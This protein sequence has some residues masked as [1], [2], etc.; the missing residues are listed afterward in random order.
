M[1]IIYS[2][3]EQTT[4]NDND[5][6]L[7]TS[8]ALVGGKKKNTT[9]NF[10]LSELS[11]YFGVGSI[12]NPIA[13]DFKLA[14]F[15]QGGTKI[16]DSIISQDALA[17][18]SV[19]IAGNLAA[20][21]TT[22]NGFLTVNGGASLGTGAAGELIAFGSTTRLNA[23]IQD[24]LGVVGTLDQ[25][26]ISDT[27]G[28]VS[29]QNYTSGLTY[30][31][32]WDATNNVTAP[33]GV[34]IVSSIG[35]NGE[36]YI[37][38]VAGNTQLNGQ[39]VTPTTPPYW[40]V[41]DWVVFVENGAAGVWQKIDNTSVLT[42]TG[43]DNKIAM[44]TGG[45]TPSV[46]LTDS[47]ISQDAGASTVTVAGAFTS[48]GNINGVN[49]TGT[50][51]LSGVNLLLT[52]TVSLNTQ[53]GNSGQVLTSQGTA[54]AIWANPTPVNNIT[55]SGTAN[56]LSMF[57][58]Q[59]TVGDSAVTQSADALTVDVL[60][61]TVSDANAYTINTNIG[62]LTRTGFFPGAGS[63]TSNVTIGAQNT[64]GFVDVYGS[65]M[66]LRTYNPPNTAS[67]PITLWSSSTSGIGISLRTE[68][69]S[70][71][72]LAGTYSI[73]AI[74]AGAGSNPEAIQIS[75]NTGIKFQ[76]QGNAANINFRSYN[77]N[78]N[79]SG[80]INF[81]SE[82]QEG[83]AG[84]VSFS[85][86]A[87]DANG[88]A[89]EIRLA[90]AGISTS[91]TDAVPLGLV[92]ASNGHVKTGSVGDTYTLGS[93]TDGSNVK[94]NLDAANG[95]DSAVT[96][97]G[98]GGLTIAQ[99]ND[100]VTLTAPASSDTTYTLAAG[101]KSATSVPLNLTPSTGS[102]T[103]VNLT[104][105]TGITLTQTSATEITIAGVAQ[106]VT[107]S[108]TVN[109]LPKF[110]TTT[111]LSDSIV[112]QGGGTTT[113]VP[114]NNGP[115]ISASI[116]FS[117]QASSFVMA[118]YATRNTVTGPAPQVGDV[119][120]FVLTSDLTWAIGGGVIPA[121]TYPFTITFVGSGSLT[122]NFNSYT[123]G[124]GASGTGYTNLVGNGSSTSVSSSSNLSIDGE[125]SMLT[126][127]I[128]NVVNPI[129]NQDAATKA[130]VDNVVSGQLIF[131]GSYDATTAPPFGPSILQGFTYVVNVAGDYGGLWPIPLAVG[132]LIISN[133]DNPVDVGDYT[134]VNKQVDIATDT[135]LGIANFP[136]GNNGL[137]V[138]SG[139][140]TAKL[141]SGTL[142]G[143]VPDATSAPAGTFL[144][145]DGTWAV[146]GVGSVTNFSTVS[147]A[148]PGITTTVTNPTSTPE[149]VLG[150]GANAAA[151]K[152]LDGGTGDWVTL[153]ASGVTSVN[154]GTPFN[155]TGLPL[156]ISPTSGAV[157][158]SSAVY[159]GGSNIGVVPDGGSS[160]T[161][162]KGDGSWSL[163]GIVGI[164]AGTPYTSTGLPLDISTLNG[165][166]SISLGVYNG[167]SNIGIVPDSG[168]AT[169]FLRG[170]GQWASPTAASAT[171]TT[172]SAVGDGT[173]LT[174]ALGA[175][176]NGGSSSFVD[177]FIDGVY[178]EIST[179][180]ISGTNLV[181]DAG[182]A[183]PAGTN[184]ET[185]TIADYNVGAVVTTASLGQA[186]TTGN[187]N[188]RIIPN[189][190]TSNITAQANNLYIFDSTTQ[191]YTLTLPSS[192]QPGD[193]IKISIRGGLTTNTLAVPVTENI[194]GGVLGNSLVINNATAAFE[195][196]Y[197]G[198][199]TKQGWVIIG[200]V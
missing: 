125:L 129:D 91:A 160:T 105:G 109:K 49:I 77:T 180:S 174:F 152:Y 176:P 111:S 178:Q 72:N 88:T 137:N 117:S 196:I 43:T 7:G 34:P 15:N 17:G 183:P 94:L 165:S 138:S 154:G 192:P 99:T 41:G 24:Q 158:I 83:Q 28:R 168:T 67:S 40:N 69:G 130:Y 39:P 104:E 22:L 187:V 148:Y 198:D 53:L 12:I 169:T 135:V 13:S 175:T 33:Q 181:F 37:V 46:T 5:T 68:G 197:S 145:E 62:K 108:G 172:R 1:S 143:Y 101:V 59:Y 146:A 124:S 55:G 56:T 133:Q 190:I 100:I 128:T 18:T 156:N 195:I 80:D 167:G 35:T 61:K 115:G 51:D 97:T 140:V 23:P 114:L 4:L 3:P 200:N 194:M 86:I 57:T 73:Q 121:G 78:L 170:D 127:K 122:C 179:Y 89:G 21:T 113:I 151:G 70:I 74:G 50:G 93:S 189:Y 107:G 173:N 164:T 2:Y 38:T 44:W 45:A 193:S 184:V 60:T 102:G 64:Y 136:T 11:T 58:G 153:P 144:K 27:A 112:E 120:N 149:L 199:S 98:A 71:S 123:T 186:N 10:S 166:T 185:K 14:V 32:T 126:N 191:A 19:T 95:T 132:D 31:G 65:N 161:F 147:T 20:N 157:T 29:W 103:A 76:G 141:F 116:S 25:I 118:D 92:I 6:L 90:G 84:N 110:D 79:D 142:P 54:D 66:E 85:S 134:E 177:V 119:F 182:N 87:T 159:N 81:I 42:G 52:G 16:T 139:A 131:E 155:S 48:T 26:L 163:P 36:F 47:L 162:L 96:L 82:T 75:S 8:A 188:L 150:L 171:I 9:R 30:T 106:G 63:L